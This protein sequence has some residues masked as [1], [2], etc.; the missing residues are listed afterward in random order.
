[1]MQEYEHTTLLLDV[2]LQANASI[3]QQF[4]DFK[5]AMIRQTNTEQKDGGL[6]R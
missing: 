3:P 5:R 2:I 4:G 6:P 1:M